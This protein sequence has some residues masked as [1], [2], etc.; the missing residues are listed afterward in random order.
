MAMNADGSN[1]HAITPPLS[2]LGSH[3]WS[4]DGISIAID[5]DADGDGWNELAVMNAD[6]TGLHTLYDPGVQPV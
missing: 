4:P 1:Q 3:A 6:G 5:Y 2:Y